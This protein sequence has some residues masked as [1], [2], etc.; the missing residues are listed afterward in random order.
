MDVRLPASGIAAPLPT[1]TAV[2]GAIYRGLLVG[3]SGR[4]G[5]VKP[6]SATWPDARG[7]FPIV[8]PPSV[9][10][11]TLRFWQSEFQTYTTRA[12]PGG[13]VILTWPTRLSPRVPRDTGFVRVRARRPPV[14]AA[15]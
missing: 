4:N 5:L 12:A 14:A 15:R 6:I 10:G 3:V 8:L 1:T 9:K 11:Q 7:R 2:P 13:P